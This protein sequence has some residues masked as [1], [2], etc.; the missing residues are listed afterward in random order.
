MAILQGVSKL[1]RCVIANLAIL[2]SQTD[3]RP[4]H[5]ID[6]STPAH[7]LSQMVRCPSADRTTPEVQILDLR[8]SVQDRTQGTGPLVGQATSMQVQLFHADLDLS[9]LF[10][11]TDMQTLLSAAAQGVDQ[12][13]HCFRLELGPCK[14]DH[15][16]A[17]AVP[18]S[19]RQSLCTL[20]I[21][22]VSRN[23]DALEALRCQET[24]GQ[25]LSPRV[26]Y[27]V[28]AQLQ[29]F[30]HGNLT[31]KSIGDKASSLV[32]DGVALQNHFLCFGD[33]ASNGASPDIG[34]A[35][36]RQIDHLQLL[37]VFQP[38]RQTG[39][40]HVAEAA[41]A[42]IQ[43]GELR[44]HQSNVG[45][46]PGPALQRLVVGVQA[47]HAPLDHGWVIR[48]RQRHLLHSRDATH[49]LQQFRLLLDVDCQTCQV[50]LLERPV[51]L[52]RIENRL[53]TI[54]SDHQI[55]DAQPLDVNVSHDRS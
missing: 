32:R 38:L 40:A 37:V 46:D 11:H 26:L 48:Q 12:R 21:N 45:Q 23:I 39:G 51:T 7:H 47:R 36:I 55:A 25:F 18:D 43:P 2:E 15:L 34:D 50:H 9:P 54:I 8:T 35:A 53:K 17:A 31:G 52:E 33:N 10:R 19:I 49:H 28:I 14:I 27:G 5:T 4:L 44:T 3:Q 16:Q 22:G 29:T 24:A 30:S 42:Q 13:H 41:L 20:R 6:A 1:A